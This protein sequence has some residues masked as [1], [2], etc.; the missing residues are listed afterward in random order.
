MTTLPD[1]EVDFVDFSC[2]W[3]EKRNF[4]LAQNQQGVL[5]MI[6]TPTGYMTSGLHKL[7]PLYTVGMTP[8]TGWY[9]KSFAESRM[10]LSQ[11]FSGFL[12]AE[13]EHMD[14]WLSKPENQVALKQEILEYF[15]QPNKQCLKYNGN[16]QWSMVPF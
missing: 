6:P 13:T 9:R 7:E 5:V 16:R 3:S 1:I 8:L 4:V 12:F 11:T 10:S 15:S 14:R 2:S